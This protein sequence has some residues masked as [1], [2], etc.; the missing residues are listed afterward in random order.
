MD[1]YL[2]LQVHQRVNFCDKY[3]F[4]LI[5]TFIKNDAKKLGYFCLLICCSRLGIEMLYISTS[6]WVL[7]PP[8]QVK[9][10]IF[11]VFLF[12]KLKKLK[13]GKNLGRNEKGCL[14]LTSWKVQP[15][16]FYLVDIDHPALIYGWRRQNRNNANLNLEII[17]YFLFFKILAFLGTF[18]IRACF[19]SLFQKY[20]KKSKFCK[21]K[22]MSLLIPPEKVNKM[23]WTIWIPN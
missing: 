5:I 9:I 3:W 4:Q 16:F 11:N 1:L 20:L 18:G 12:T 6:V 14:P 22:Q 10:C 8:K 13:K 23:I 2:S 15:E 21:I 17:K 19:V 7:C